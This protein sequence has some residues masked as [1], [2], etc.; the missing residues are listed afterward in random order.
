[1]IEHLNPQ[2]FISQ[3]RAHNE[4]WPNCQDEQFRQ[5]EF[6]V[7]VGQTVFADHNRYFARISANHRETVA[8]RRGSFHLPT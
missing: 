5:E 3:A 6:P 8:R 2:A 7:T 1:M 4:A